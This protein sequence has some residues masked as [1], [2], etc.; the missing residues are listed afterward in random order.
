M[1]MSNERYDRGAEIVS[2][3]YGNVGAEFLSAVREVAPDLPRYVREFA[4]GDV[5]SRP[6]LDPKIR[7]IAILASLTTLGD[8]AHEIRAHVHGALNLGVTREEIVETVIQTSVYAG[9]PRAI[10]AVRIVAEVFRERDAAE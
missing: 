7:E 10:A 1:S 5:Y 3:I 9:F 4:F 8:T 6:G 2:R